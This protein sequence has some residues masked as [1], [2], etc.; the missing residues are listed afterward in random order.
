MTT[1]AYVGKEIGRYLA[2]LRDDADLNQN[3]VA[4]RMTWSPAVISRIE[5][6]Q[7]PVTYDELNSILDAIGTEKA[8]EFKETACRNWRQLPKPPFGHPDEPLLW[9]T[10]QALQGISILL[11]DPDIRNSFAA[12]LREIKKETLDA[13]RLVRTV[14][15]SIAFIGDVG[16]GKST[17]ICRLLGLEIPNQKRALDTSVLEVG[18]GRVTICEVQLAQ[19]PEFGILV[20]P[21]SDSEIYRE[22][23]EFA[24]Q[25]KH[26]PPSESQGLPDEGSVIGTSIEFERAIR[27]MSGLIQVRER[28]ADGR[29]TRAPDPAKELADGTSDVDELTTEILGR[30]NL[31]TRTRR[32][33]WYPSDQPSVEPLVWLKDNFS[34]LNK[35]QHLDFSIPRLVNIM[36]PKYI[37]GEES[38]SIRVI[39]TRGVDGT[40]ERRDIDNLVSDPST[41][42][43]LCSPFN[44]TPSL[45]VRQLL[46]RTSE[47]MVP[48]I[49]HKTA[50]LGL[51]RGEEALAVRYDDGQSV[52]SSDEGYDIKRAEAED[53][54]AQVEMSNVPV[55]FFNALEDDAG[56][57]QNFLLELV[58]NLRRQ[59][60][61]ELREL[62]DDTRLLASNLEEELT[63]AVQ[64]AAAKRL[65][66]WL[67][68]NFDL[69]T[70]SI[71]QLDRTLTRAIKN[72]HPGSVHASI[73]RQGDW[74]NLD[75]SHLI[76]SGSRLLVAR[77]VRTELTNLQAVTE[78]LLQDPDLKEA[79]SLITQA[80]R[81][82]ESGID[83]LLKRSEIAGVRVYNPYLRVDNGFWRNCEDQWGRGLG[84]RDRV[85]DRHEQWFE[86][87]TSHHQVAANLRS[88]VDKEWKETLGRLRDILEESPE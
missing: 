42:A 27:N 67:K 49:Q 88:L 17:A 79:F 37:L 20:E 21:M 13:E 41:I 43:V 47:S 39:D 28:G 87:S 32:E 52:E 63:R 56:K 1:E 51:P 19:G 77:V 66:T 70:S 33:V 86:S 24:N 4:Q 69:D 80:R 2:H 65:A 14:E 7:R 57:I 78:N 84:Y 34:K 26:E 85:A 60:C 61:N 71:D 31:S 3:E 53:R 75:Y 76:S 40:L 35:G 23:R 64:A 54:L 30:M 29:Y 15:Y 38:L 18:S 82:V 68:N 62:I 74:Y 81:V 12:R 73:R 9:D 44:S 16:L 58:K 50:I 10:E 8:F 59:Y 6:G 22:V 45:P 72:A 55:E 5:S 48:R 36:V 46:E 83:G 11:E 25:L